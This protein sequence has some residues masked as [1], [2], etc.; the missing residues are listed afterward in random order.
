MMATKLPA[1]RPRSSRIPRRRRSGREAV[2]RPK[3]QSSDSP[4]PMGRWIFELLHDDTTQCPFFSFFRM[5]IARFNELLCCVA[6][7]QKTIISGALLFFSI[8]RS[9]R[10]TGKGGIC[11]A[12]SCQK[13]EQ[14]GPSDVHPR[15]ERQKGKTYEHIS[16]FSSTLAI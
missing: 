7:V 9:Y 14:I 8:R 1:L 12:V 13:I 10:W 2:R 4:L 16:I 5:P 15:G 6:L 3:L 11:D